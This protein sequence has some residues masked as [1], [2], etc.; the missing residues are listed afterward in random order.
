MSRREEERLGMPEHHLPQGEPFVVT[1]DRA[2]DVDRIQPNDGRFQILPVTFAINFL[3]PG[4]KMHLV[5]AKGRRRRFQS[6]L[7]IAFEIKLLRLERSRGLRVLR[8]FEGIDGSN[9]GNRIPNQDAGKNFPPQNSGGG[10][11]GLVT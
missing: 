3:S 9:A 4:T 8:A 6:P 10:R 11:D 5:V 1:L 7:D 2:D